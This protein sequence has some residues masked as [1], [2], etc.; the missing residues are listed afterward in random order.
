MAPWNGPNNEATTTT[1]RVA[2]D[3]WPPAVTQEKYSNRPTADEGDRPTAPRTVSGI[4][5]TAAQLYE[6]DIR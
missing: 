2:T 4:P 6:Q 1:P 3:K 5:F